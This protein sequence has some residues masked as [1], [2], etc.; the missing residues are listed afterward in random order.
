V[1]VAVPWQGTS[2]VITGGAGFIGSHLCERLVAAGA[3]VTVI[4]DLSHGHAGNLEAVNGAFRMVHHRLGIAQELPSEHAEGDL[5]FHCAA[6]ADPR[7]CNQNPELA[8]QLNVTATEE[9]LRQWQGGR[10]V[11]LSTAAA[12]GDPRYIPIDEHHPL[13]PKDPYAESKVAAERLFERY[14]RE[15]G[16]A[17]TIV[18]NFNVYGPRQVQSYF[19]PTLIAQAIR[20]RRISIWNGSPIRDMN[21]IDDAIDALVAIGADDRT[22][23]EILNLGSGE[24]RKM[25]DLARHV[26]ALF[27]VSYFDQGKDVIG[28]RELV[29]DNSKIRRLTGWAPSTPLDEGLARTVAYF[30]KALGNDSRP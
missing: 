8:R 13:G 9:V 25:E 11:F 16:L 10:I 15:R 23:G 26:A 19:V 6:L 2:V 21:Y 24:G 17:A 27:E 20:D 30:R 22:S 14:G 4:D 29:C 7:A 5:L 3:R 18:R 12:Y 28:S 1:N